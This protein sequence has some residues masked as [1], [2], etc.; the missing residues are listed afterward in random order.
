IINGEVLSSYVKG[1]ISKEVT[2]D[3]PRGNI[4]D[5]F[6]RPLA[7]NNSS[8]T[9]NIDPS[10]SLEEEELNSIILKTINLLEAN[11][12]KIVDDF[13]ISKEKP[14]TFLFNDSASLEKTW[15]GDM[16]LE[17]NSLKLKPEEITAEQAFNILREKFSVDPNLSDED[18]R[19]ILMVRSE[20]YKKR[21]L[22]FLPITL[23][24][25]VSKKTI[26]T[27]EEN[28]Y[29]FA[30]INIDVEATREYPEKHLFSHILGYIR[31]INSEELEQYQK[32]GFKNYDMNDIV[33][34]EGIEKAFETTLKGIDGTAYY[35]VDTKGKK[36]RENNEMTIPPVPGND[37]FLTTDT[38][39]T[40]VAFNALE[41]ELSQTIKN[42]LLSKNKNINYSSKDI[43]TA[44]VSSNN[45]DIKKVIASEDGSYQ[46]ILKNYIYNQDK[47]ALNNLENAREILASGVKNNKVSQVNI[48]MAL[49]EQGFITADSNYKK[50]VSIG[51]ISPLQVLLD[52]LESGEL[53]PQMTGLPEAPA[54]GSVFVTD[55]TGNILTS[56]SYPS[57]DNNMFVNIFNN[58]YYAKISQDPT[59]PLTNRPL[60]EPRAPG[61]IF[62]MIP[63]VAALETGLI[64]PN[65]TIYD[66]G[67]FTE[68]GKPYARCWIGNGHGS[69]GHVN[70]AT[71]LEVSC[72]YFYYDVSYRMGIET[73]NRYMEAFGLNDK[74]GVEIYELYD[75]SSIQK[76]PS[77]ISS[78]DYKRYITALRNP[79]ATESDLKW[80]AGN[81]IR[82]AIG[83][84]F[85]NY[86]SAT[87]TKYIATLANGGKRYS[88]HFLNKITDN[89]GNV[90][91]EYVP[92]LEYEVEMSD[93]TL[94]AIRQ[95]MYQVT[96][97]S[98]GTLRA[99]FKDF[100]FKVAA[101]SGTAQE[102]PKKNDH[103]VF[104]CFAPYDNPQIAITVIIPYGDDTYSP[105]P[106]IAKK[107][108]TEYFGLEKQPEKSYSNQLNP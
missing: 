81:T 68:A 91:K 73:M 6:G 30:S 41:Y 44:I 96:S 98:H 93:S 57:Y 4:Y 59:N 100:P 20:L 24:Y 64:T 66:K 43:L 45:L 62:K 36:V 79:D 65:T 16:N 90:Q 102:S 28:S 80:T 33:G 7:I 83:Q 13:P 21:Y 3:A 106:K 34:K 70:L 86:T 101:K 84:D 8:F 88:L 22:R 69:H 61:S 48:V 15:K 97:G 17:D 38:N 2:L 55:L 46:S 39:L 89:E 27:I 31:G 82:T 92:N 42:R 103:N 71:S 108:I 107:I 35:E 52:K 105:A 85:N 12:E 23:A 63:A 104:T 47:E 29:E 72:N 99:H 60:T 1:T 19:K 18:A 25:D 9:V 74:T 54:T 94:K 56:V 50:R 14:Y 95:G 76:Y 53:T 10:V 11:N 37:V 26:G 32:D 40:E 78:P 5:R 51:N 87:M 49:F 58:E 77:K 75:H 67:T